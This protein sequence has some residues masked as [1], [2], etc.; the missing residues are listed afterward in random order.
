MGVRWG[1]L[2]EREGTSCRYLVGFAHVSS[3]RSYVRL[4]WCYYREALPGLPLSEHV[5]ILQ[6]SYTEGRSLVLYIIIS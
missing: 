5:E 6:V 1:G 2:R 3:T 4:L